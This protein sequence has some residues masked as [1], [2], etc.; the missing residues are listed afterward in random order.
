MST[1]P[2]AATYADVQSRRMRYAYQAVRA[3]I[4]IP[5]SAS[6]ADTFP[7]VTS[8]NGTINTGKSM[9]R[10]PRSQNRD[11]IPDPTP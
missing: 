3:T 1:A 7:P 10:Q 8:R 5:T 9:G 11:A 4:A 2:A 6:V